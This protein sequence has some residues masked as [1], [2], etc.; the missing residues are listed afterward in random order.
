MYSTCFV[1]DK[2]ESTYT[3]NSLKS[4]T[5]ST[6]PESVWSEVALCC[7][8]QG[9][10]TSSLSAVHYLVLSQSTRVT[11]RRTDRINYDTQDRA[12]IA[13]S[14][15]KNPRKCRDPDSN[16]NM[17][18]FQV[19]MCT[20]CKTCSSEQGRPIHPPKAIDALLPLPPLVPPLSYPFYLLPHFSAPPLPL[21]IGH[22]NL[23]G[24][25]GAL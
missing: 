5:R 8:P 14:R 21:E 22:S 2:V 1:Q 10:I 17:L 20:Y 25:W 11:D 18:R 12:N 13:A 6:A 9:P 3:P 7:W 24:V 4:W 15:G 19:L 16:V 23:S